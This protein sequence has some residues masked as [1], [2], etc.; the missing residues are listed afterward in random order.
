VK[1]F[2]LN[3]I[4]RFRW[5]APILS[6]IYEQDSARFV[7]I[8]KRLGISRSVLTSTLGKL[9]EDGLVIRNPGHGHPLRPEYLLTP[10]GQ[11]I[12]PFCFDLIKCI[13]KH[14]T[15]CLIQS[16]WALRIM[17][18]LVKSDFRF[19]ELKSRLKPITSRALSNELKYLGSEGYIRRKIVD[20]YPPTTHYELAPKS[21]PFIRVLEKNKAYF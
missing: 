16:R 15:W 12:A 1:S 10:E 7:T 2:K 20:D 14:N 21:S 3:N 19:S 13:D 4:F 5:S 18:L 6:E 8:L 17:F 11:K 9:V